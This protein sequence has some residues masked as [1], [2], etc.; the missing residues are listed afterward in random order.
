MDDLPYDFFRSV[1]RLLQND[2]KKN[3]KN[4]EKLSSPW[5][6]VA[7]RTLKRRLHLDFIFESRSEV[8]FKAAN[9]NSSPKR[10]VWNKIMN[11]LRKAEFDRISVRE[12]D[13]VNHSAEYLT[14]A[15]VTLIGQVLQASA[16]SVEVDFKP[17]SAAFAKVL[18]F[19]FYSVQRIVKV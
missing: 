13:G 5:A 3:L 14:N 7:K 2:S 16:Q 4:F 11:E 9:P 12:N 6:L 19:L 18:P 8:C 1:C 10:V 17:S 15:N